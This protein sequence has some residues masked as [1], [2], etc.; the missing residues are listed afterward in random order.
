[1]S[2]TTMH[3]RT[4]LF[5]VVLIT[6]MTLPELSHGQEAPRSLG[7]GSEVLD[8]I[9]GNEEGADADKALAL[10]RTVPAGDSIFERVLMRRVIMELD[11]KAYS[12]VLSTSKLGIRQHG[13]YEY[14]F[15][16]EKIAALSGTK[17]YAEAEAYA[18]S[19][20]T[21]YP[22]NFIFP[23]I[24]ALVVDE[25]GD[26][27]RAL[28]L[29]K[30]NVVRFPTRADAHVN[31]GDI[32]A[33]EGKTAQAALCYATATI[34]HYGTSKDERNVGDL[35]QLLGGTLDAAPK[36]GDLDKGED[37]SE[38]DLLLKNR[39]AMAKG[40]KVKPDL[41]YP[42]CRQSHL[43]F[44]HLKDH[45]A[46]DGFWS[47]YYVPLFNRI[48]AENLFEG[49]IYNALS[50]AGNEQVLALAKKKSAVVQDF[51]KAIWPV[52]MDLYQTYPDSP[53]GTPVKHWFLESGSL[54][55]VGDGN[56]AADV[57]SGPWTS[58]HSNGSI[59]AKGT[60]SANGKRM[61][62]WNEYFDDGSLQRI[63]Q[64]DAD[65]KENGVRLLYYRTGA[66]ND[67]VRFINDKPDGTYH[68][69][70]P[71][72]TLK[73]AKTFAQDKV[74]G[75]AISY[76]ACGTV[77]NR[78]TLADD[79]ADGRVT[80]YYADGAQQYNGD[81]QAGQRTGV[82]TTFHHNGKKESEYGYV[83]GKASGPYTEWWPEGNLKRKGT[84]T[85]DLVTGA[86]SS[87]EANGQLASVRMLDLK[88]RSNG[89]QTNFAN[90]LAYEVDEYTNDLLVR[91][92]FLDKKGNVIQEGARKKGK[93]QFSGYTSRG[94][95][96]SR[97]EYLDEGLKD[98][99]WQYF[100]PDGTVSAEE[101]FV[102]GKM[103][104]KQTSY[105]KN[106]KVRI[107]YDY[108]LP[109]RTGTYRQFYLNGKPKYI[110][111]LVQ[112]RLSGT[113]RHYLP[114]GTLN[115]D[116]YYVDGDRSGWQDYYDNNGKPVSS[117]LVV[118]GKISE[119]IIYGAEGLVQAHHVVPP[120]PYT[121][122][123][124]FADGNKMDEIPMMNGTYH[125][126]AT[127]FYPNGNKRIEGRYVNGERD[128]LWTWYFPDGKK[129]SEEF[130]SLDEQ[131]GTER[132][133]YRSGQLSNE[134]T[135]THGER[136]G[137]YL[138]YWENGQVNVERHYEHGKESGIA[139]NHAEDGTLQYARFFDQDELI[140]Y[141]QPKT[142][143][144]IGDTVYTAP[145][146]VE[147]KSF[148]DNGKPSRLFIYMDGEIDGPYKAWHPN[149]QL[150]EE[151][152]YE[153][154]SRTGTDNEYYANGQLRQVSNYEEDV[155]H[156]PILRYA[157]NGKLIEQGTFHYGSLEGEYKV[158]DNM[159]KLVATYGY[160][161]GV[162]T[163]MK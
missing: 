135:Y 83:D 61:G 7:Y 76:F 60:L 140:G 158:W 160:Q 75:P 103:Q 119:K 151:E 81:Y 98:G 97:G 68:H 116:E 131:T 65:G 130:W 31:L 101:H 156:G 27:A 136:N 47:T 58:Y 2:N 77:E 114:D 143:G 163:S 91:Y 157:E 28:E 94:T 141:A 106:G 142:G 35:D 42:I 34:M 95:L 69:H 66:L 5:L 127:W 32:A 52:L 59:A 62:T 125:G 102:K 22:G 152:V 67:S 41:E 64:Y 144:T 43:L 139:K 133:W 99:V 121:L 93:F 19:C 148:Y 53:G 123:E 80:S 51:R 6:A 128:G 39:V 10:L 82:H 115:E 85:N 24:K 113:Y 21:K 57:Y 137:P 16:F 108:T 162:M 111:W 118:D 13:E 100:L 89:T 48:M 56:A 15:H 30:A 38:I 124:T 74:N 145:G 120:G 12:E 109:D 126:A 9:T 105:Y 14:L 161:N 107:E 50:S 36:G 63:L 154:G 29:F 138:S 110:G 153:A 87:W 8:R 84:M 96:A 159:G 18:D 155:R 73:L 117:N 134:S 33:Q 70:L 49:F 45:P 3:L 112:G 86:D 23:N 132:N 26:R 122:M 25:S 150:E 146:K 149:G 44:S 55:G 11:R 147:I 104:G 88:G 37:F 20:I 17:K 54:N 79:K 4:S 78:Y 1:M 90:G 46:G 71:D 40:Y 129:L 72:G 92:R